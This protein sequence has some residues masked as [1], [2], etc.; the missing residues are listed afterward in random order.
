MTLKAKRT[1]SSFVG[2]ITHGMPHFV[3]SEPEA[4]YVSSPILHV[5]AR[6]GRVLQSF[7]DGLFVL[8]HGISIAKDS[9]GK[10]TALW[11]TDVALHQVM[12]FDWNK[13]TKPALV[14]GRRDQPGN[15]EDTFCSP[16]D[17]AVASTVNMKHES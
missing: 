5:D 11:V 6:S 2:V 1:S 16:T 10:P 8:P 9:A 3:Y 15:D 14:L 13:W 12:K 4:A 17:V 7:G